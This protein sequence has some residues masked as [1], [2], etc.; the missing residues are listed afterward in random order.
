[1]VQAYGFY[2]CYLSCYFMSGLYQTGTNPNF[3]VC[4]VTGLSDNCS[5][6]VYDYYYYFFFFLKELW[7][8]VNKESSTYSFE[9]IISNN[10][11]CDFYCSVTCCYTG[12]WQDS[13]YNERSDEENWRKYRC[14]LLFL[15]NVVFTKLITSALN[16]I[17]LL[18]ACV[19]SSSLTVV[20]SA[21][22][23]ALN[24]V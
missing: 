11:C 13:L 3:R 19:R 21:L 4:F 24:N 14:F 23:M 17:M 9:N 2:E 20:E 8:P 15:T 16:L 22:T 12:R 1:M 18:P 5:L 6:H 7:H 10:K